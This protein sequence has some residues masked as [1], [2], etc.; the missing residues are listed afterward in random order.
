MQQRPYVICHMSPS[1]DGKIVSK[2]LAL[3]ELAYAAYER[4]ATTPTRTPWIVGR[5][6]M[7]PYAASR[8]CRDSPE[9]ADAA[10]GFHRRGKGA[11]VRHRDRSVG[12]THVAI[13]CHR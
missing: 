2:E 1:I 13:E 11:V 6:S 12:E 3:P 4:T 9:A 7:A 5:V 8:E 10:K